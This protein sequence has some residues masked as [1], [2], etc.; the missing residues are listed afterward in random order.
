MSATY[1]SFCLLY[2]KSFQRRAKGRADTF[3][4]RHQS[5]AFAML[6][7][8]KF[9]DFSL[10]II[11]SCIKLASFPNNRYEQSS[12]K[13]VI[14][15]Y[16]A[17]KRRKTAKHSKNSYC[18]IPQELLAAI[19]PWSRPRRPDRIKNVRSAHLY[20]GSPRRLLPTC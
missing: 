16:S 7:V 20:D 13:G 5:L 8:R 11:I 3:L 14:V 9:V 4:M 15:L 2:H 17:R 19:T 6:M 10:Q 12:I 1:V 18:R